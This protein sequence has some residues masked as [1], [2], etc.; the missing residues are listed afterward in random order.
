MCVCVC[1]CVCVCEYAVNV[2]TC[3]YI[4]QETVGKLI[5]YTAE[6]TDNNFFTFVCVGLQSVALGLNSIPFLEQ[7]NGPGIREGFD[8][9][10][11]SWG[12]QSDCRR[13]GNTVSMAIT[14]YDVII[15][16]T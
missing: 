2:Y 7:G 15:R 3:I 5:R 13:L 9:S 8:L 14:W 12:D 1:V 16:V 10:D 11:Y 4:T 6:H